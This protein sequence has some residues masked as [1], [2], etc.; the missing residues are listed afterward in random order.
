MIV[1]TMVSLFAALLLF[2]AAGGQPAAQ[3]ATPETAAPALSELTDLDQLREQFN[4]QH[5]KLRL[6]LLVAPT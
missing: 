1:Q 5:G 3:E 6:L 2:A 4:E